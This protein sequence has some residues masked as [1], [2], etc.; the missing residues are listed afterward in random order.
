MQIAGEAGPQNDPGPEHRSHTDQS[1]GNFLR[2]RP[3][4]LVGH[5]PGPKGEG[6]VPQPH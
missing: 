2:L 3:A 5:S 1:W 4:T 6:L